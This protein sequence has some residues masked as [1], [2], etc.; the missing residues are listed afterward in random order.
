LA[1]VLQPSGQWP[2]WNVS[3]EEK[4]DGYSR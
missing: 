4:R 2:K 1:A 3:Y